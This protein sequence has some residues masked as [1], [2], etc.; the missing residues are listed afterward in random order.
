MV[1]DLAQEKP[2]VTNISVIAIP[3]KELSKLPLGWPA[4]FLTH[5]TLARAAE[6]TED[7]TFCVSALLEGGGTWRALEA[8]WKSESRSYGIT[9]ANGNVQ[10]QT[11]GT[12]K[13]GSWPQGLDSVSLCWVPRARVP[14]E[15][16]MWP[17]WSAR[18]NQ[19]WSDGEKAGLRLK[20]SGC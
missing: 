5:G 9:G 19:H 11:W 18:C 3:L 13:M 6:H 15:M 4:C 7:T 12:D 14:I 1:S 8:V 2:S 20:L 16:L 17:W 10:M